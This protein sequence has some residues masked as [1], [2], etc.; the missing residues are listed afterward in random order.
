MAS[1]TN[2]FDEARLHRA[3]SGVLHKTEAVAAAVRSSPSKTDRTASNY[4]IDPAVPRATIVGCRNHLD[5]RTE[6]RR[7]GPRL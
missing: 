5:A 2:P 1:M 6:L 3:P 4:R 7:L